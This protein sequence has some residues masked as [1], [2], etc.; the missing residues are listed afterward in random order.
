MK[1]RSIIHGDLKIP[2]SAIYEAKNITKKDILVIDWEH[3]ELPKLASPFLDFFMGEYYS[4]MESYYKSVAINRVKN[5][6][7][8]G[9]LYGIWKDLKASVDAIGKVIPDINI[10]GIKDL[11]NLLKCKIPNEVDY[12]LEEKISKVVDKHYPLL[13]ALNFYAYEKDMVK[14]LKDYVL[15]GDQEAF[16]NCL[17]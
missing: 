17:N 8:L 6:Q 14:H 11:A 10:S 16:K 1:N 7:K 13:N 15:S 12:K 4:L 3:G 9:F 5:G 2:I